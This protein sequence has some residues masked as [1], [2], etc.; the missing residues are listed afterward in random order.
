MRNN[1]WLPPLA[2]FLFCLVSRTLFAGHYLEGWDSVNFALGLRTF[3]ITAGQPHFPGY[4]IY[5]FFARILLKVIGDDA[6]ALTL[7]GAFFGSLALLPFYALARKMFSTSVA[8]LASLLFLVDPLL[9]LQAEKAYS[10]ACGLFFLMTWAYLLYRSLAQEVDSG[11]LESHRA[12]EPKATSLLQRIQRLWQNNAFYF[13]GLWLGLA[14][15]VRL[16]YFPF[17][18]TFL[19]AVIFY[20]RI[21]KRGYLDSLYGLILGTAIWL[22]PLLAAAG[23][24]NLETQGLKHLHGHLYDWGGTLV[25]S[26]DLLERL[27][28]FLWDLLANGLGFWW[29]DVSVVRLIPSVIIAISFILYARTT[30]FDMK[31]KYLLAYL[32][33]Y[34]LWVFA[35]QNLN[36]P[37][38]FLPLLPM[39]LLIV[40]AGLWQGV[41]VLSKSAGVGKG[42]RV[43]AS[44]L[45]IGTL[46]VTSLGLVR[47]HKNTPPTRVQLVE[48]VAQHFPKES[49]VIY[50][51]NTKRLFDYYAPA[52]HTRSKLPRKARF[53]RTASREPGT[54]L[55]TSDYP[56]IAELEENL[57][58]LKTFTR[59][60]YVHNWFHE[61]HLYQ[62]Q[63]SGHLPGLEYL[64]GVRK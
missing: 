6:L 43:S 46:G 54:V 34:F 50:C 33:P 20:R 55:V 32:L 39:L 36:S 3:D 53:R 42:I 9:W 8:I 13:A 4:P 27:K 21:H 18:L 19:F 10:D 31:A 38:H 48:Y 5:I 1:L 14:L 17:L 47:S 60:R 26:G 23:V 49:T 44:A 57:V 37:R 58:L 29:P 7:T 11:G 24:K 63:D 25:V 40:A 16:S 56:A 61:L 62:L 30:R 52:I 28:M 22:V 64:E 35:G 2:L 15:G 51:W 12:A 59:S 41:A 45:L